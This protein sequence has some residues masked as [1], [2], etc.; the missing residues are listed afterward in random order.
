[1]NYFSGNSRKLDKDDIKN[2]SNMVDEIYN[3]LENIKPQTINTKD[4][5]KQFYKNK[6]GL[7]VIPEDKVKTKTAGEY[8]GLTDNIVND[9]ENKD[10]ARKG[11][12]YL[13]NKLS[14]GTFCPEIK[15]YFDEM[16]ESRGRERGSFKEKRDKIKSEENQKNLRRQNFLEGHNQDK[17]ANETIKDDE[18]FKLNFRNNQN[19]DKGILKQLNT[20]N[21]N[22]GVKPITFKQRTKSRKNKYNK[23]EDVKYSNCKIY[24][25]DFSERELI[26][27]Y[28]DDEIENSNKKYT[29]V[30]AD[31]RKFVFRSKN[32]ENKKMKK[33]NQNIKKIRTKSNLD[34]MGSSS[35]NQLL[36]SQKN[37]L[38]EKSIPLGDKKLKQAKTRVS[39][40]K[41]SVKF[42]NNMNI[43]N[44]VGIKNGYLE[45]D[46]NSASI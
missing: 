9:F 38:P 25:N 31:G 5:A 26:L 17:V 32:K 15:E 11:L 4:R 41:S 3:F 45:E 10:K 13:L 16:R 7:D 2:S 34:R 23:D 1:M 33:P 30:G 12:L 19:K 22:M 37:M 20:L 8:K 46:E 21:N 6:Q 43:S 14:K 35:Y 28:S 44:A 27:F 29:T 18:L 40:Q 36:T 24:K 42:P 39:I